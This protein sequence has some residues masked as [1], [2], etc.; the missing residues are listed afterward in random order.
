M[1]RYYKRHLYDGTHKAGKISHAVKII[2]REV[3]RPVDGPGAGVICHLS[4]GTWEF[5]H[6]LI[7]KGDYHV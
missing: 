2:K 1:R 7:M 3:H 6:N 5:E 4:D